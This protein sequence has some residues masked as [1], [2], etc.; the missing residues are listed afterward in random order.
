M[1]LRPQDELERGQKS[2]GSPD[3]HRCYTLEVGMRS[4]AMGKMPGRPAVSFSATIEATITRTSVA[5]FPIS[6]LHV[7]GDTPFRFGLPIPA[8]TTGRGS[9][10]PAFERRV[11]SDVVLGGR[12]IPGTKPPA[13]RCV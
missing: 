2:S 12:D 10:F 1:S 4:P 7:Y 6:P 9:L 3:F 5:G 11:S 8:I 13:C